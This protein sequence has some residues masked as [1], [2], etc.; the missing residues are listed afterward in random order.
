M[1]DPTPSP[2][3]GH[4][5]G[6]HYQPSLAVVLIIIVLFV[7]GTFLMVRAIS[8]T[9]TSPTTTTTLAPTRTTAPPSA[10]V[11]KSRTRVQVANGTNVTN[12]AAEFTQRLITQDWDTLPPGN[13]P[14]EA[15]TIIYYNTGQLEA[16]QEIA[17]TI[18][19]S[20]SAIHPLGHLT[21]VAGASGDDVIVILGNNSAPK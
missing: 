11:I 12:L 14:H 19:V 10:R 9:S 13:G 7:G 1:S 4:A 20:K 3:D 21:P 6:S 17:T 2:R 5:S 18:K 8:P 15:T 16:A